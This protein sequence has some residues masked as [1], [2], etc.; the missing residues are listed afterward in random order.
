M[1]ADWN[2]LD[3]GIPLRFLRQRNQSAPQLF[4]RL[5]RLPKWLNLIPM[6]AQ[7][8]WLSLLYRSLTLP[9]SINPA[10]LAGG[11][12]GE[13]KLDY[14]E[15]MGPQALAC[16]AA[17][18][19]IVNE[20]PNGM[21]GATLAL[22]AA[23]LAYPVIAKPDIGWCGFGVRLVRNDAE[24][25]A[26]LSRFPRGERII[27]QRF[28][29]YEG[30]AGLYYVRRPGEAKGRLTGI[31]LRHF[32]RVQGDGV[33]SVADL[34]GDD[35]R[36]RRLGRDGLSEPCCDTAYIPAAGEIVRL[37]TIG[38]TRVGGLYED[39]TAMI[40]ETLSDAVDAIAKDMQDF[41]VGRFDVR[42]ESLES[43]IEK[44]A[45]TIIEV[46]GAGSE[47]VHAWDPKFTLSQAY[48]IVFAK[49]RMLFEIGDAMRQRGHRPIGLVK[50]AKLHGRQQR[51]IKRYPMS[52]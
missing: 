51:L 24:L 22:S 9:S 1:S 49:Q 43:L 46:N 33:S 3:S 38:S 10:I 17:F 21:T 16:T 4:G 47:A 19:S 5:E 32:P 15:V 37:A 40:S 30:E 13:G 6:V 11:M 28:L 42:Y 34:M 48:R 23:G 8:A 31:L 36:L 2:P 52:N 26:Y 27:L 25:L 14:F 44:A 12:V 41:H 50:L 39:A 20:R 7:W 35:L 29:P 18:T 45:F